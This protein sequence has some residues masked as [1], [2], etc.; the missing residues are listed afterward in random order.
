MER[1]HRIV[2][3]SGRLVIET[4]TPAELSIAGLVIMFTVG[5]GL[6]A[7]ANAVCAFAGI[8]R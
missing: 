6:L 4:E 8:V 7:L 3:R 5:F 1:R 2:E